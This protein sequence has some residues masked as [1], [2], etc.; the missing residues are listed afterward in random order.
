MS[1]KQVKDSKKISPSLT[2]NVALCSS[3]TVLALDESYG[4]MFSLSPPRFLVKNSQQH[5]FCSCA[6]CQACVSL[7]SSSQRRRPVQIT[8][9]RHGCTVQW[10]QLDLSVVSIPE[11]LTLTTVRYMLLHL[12][13]RLQ[14]H[15]ACLQVNLKTILKCICTHVLNSNNFVLFCTKTLNFSID[16]HFFQWSN[17]WRQ[18]NHF[19]M[20]QEGL[21][22][23][24]TTHSFLFPNLYLCFIS[25]HVESNLT[26]I[27]YEWN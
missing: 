12:G 16:F 2:P 3:E 22:H 15:L 11:S 8:D 18:I 24:I 17:W 23:K 25:P 20:Y 26:E 5:L 10:E 1:Q 14:N 6:Q 27:L 13:V 21:S 4:A 7:R 9:G 19:R